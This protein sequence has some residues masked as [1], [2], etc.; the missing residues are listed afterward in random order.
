MQ[1][2]ILCIGGGGWGLISGRPALHPPACYSSFGFKEPSREGGDDL[3][4]GPE[5]VEV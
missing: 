5:E 1:N 4:K 3:G 2:N